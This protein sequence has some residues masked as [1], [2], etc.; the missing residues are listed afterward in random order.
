[1]VIIPRAFVLSEAAADTPLTHARI[2][3]HNYLASLLPAAVSAS[4]ARSGF[5]ADAIL[6]PDTAEAWSPSALPA[7]ITI[8][9]G[10]AKAFDYVGVLGDFGSTGCAVE[11]D[12]DTGEV[13]TGDD[14]IFEAFSSGINPA[15][16]APL[17]FLDDQA[18]SRHVRLTITGDDLPQ[19]AVVYVGL[20]LKMQRAI[21][22][23][24]GP[25]NLSR[26][27]VLQAAMSRG[28]QFLGQSFRAHGVE[29]QLAFQNLTAAWYRENFDPF[30]KHARQLPYFVAWRPATF[31]REVVYGW[32][33]DDIRPQNIGRR[34]LMS[35]A[36]P[37]QGV[38]HE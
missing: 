37:V 1:M 21:Y 24:H 29:G 16:D 18:I 26:R 6:R 2:G 25:I 31:P 20:V 17:L 23:G 19:I 12:Y 36:F 38:G 4:S 8:D 10:A 35:V 13:D 15:D 3:Y 22:A 14:Q 33:L 9:L 34:D 27:T 5:P 28:G 32:T 30:V 7:T 11:V